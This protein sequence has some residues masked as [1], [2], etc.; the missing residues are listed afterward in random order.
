MHSQ[1]SRRMRTSLASNQ[2][3][4]LMR[5]GDD[6]CSEEGQRLR[7][8]AMISVEIA[9]PDLPDARPLLRAA[10]RT[11]PRRPNR[12]YAII[13]NRE[14]STATAFSTAI[15]TRGLISIWPGLASSQSR[16]ATLETVPIAA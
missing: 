6:D 16:D 8:Q 3:A 10:G 2:V 1:G 11:A 4:P 15:N 7:Q 9:A 5:R 14:D 13:E 12:V